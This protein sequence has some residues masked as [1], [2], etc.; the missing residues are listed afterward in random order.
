MPQAPLQAIVRP[1]VLPGCQLT[2]SHQTVSQWYNPACFVSPSSLL[3]G[4]GYGFGDSPIG[5]LRSMRFI[6][7]D[8]AL[9]KNIAITEN[10]KLQFRAEAF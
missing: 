5:N 10:K 6:N 2:P 1:S 7:M 9:V 8:V 3:V 4:P